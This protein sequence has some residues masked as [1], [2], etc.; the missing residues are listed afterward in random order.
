MDGEMIDLF[1]GTLSCVFAAFIFYF[2]HKKTESR[3]RQF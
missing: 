2:L 3:G 1:I